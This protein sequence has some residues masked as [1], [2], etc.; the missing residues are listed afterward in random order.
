M[1]LHH[2]KKTHMKKKIITALI[3][4]LAF[5]FFAGKVFISKLIEKDFVLWKFY[6]SLI[7][8]IVFSFFT[9]MIIRE[10]RILKK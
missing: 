4:N 6:A 7:A 5:L 8:V 2:V 3:L 1:Q 10:L 9:F